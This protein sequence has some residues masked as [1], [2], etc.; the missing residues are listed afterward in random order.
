M[1]VQ[2]DCLSRSCTYHH[3]P[4]DQRSVWKDRFLFIRGELV[5]RPRRPSDV[6]GHWKTI[7]KKFCL[8]SFTSTDTNLYVCVGRDFNRALLSGLIVR[9]WTRQ[10]LKIE[11]TEHDY[12][13]ALSEVNLKASRL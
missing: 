5:W 8:S 2:V 1:K 12:R 13:V 4:P 10:I 11:A 3:L 6:S 9:L 7:S